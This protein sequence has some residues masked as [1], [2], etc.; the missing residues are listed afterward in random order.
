MKKLKE[1]FLPSSNFTPQKKERFFLHH[2][3]PITAPRITRSHASTSSTH[4]QS[5][6]TRVALINGKRT[7]NKRDFPSQLVRTHSSDDGKQERKKASEIGTI[8]VVPKMRE[9]GNTRKKEKKDSLKVKQEIF[10]HLHPTTKRK[11]ES[12]G[13]F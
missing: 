1:F 11:R 6:Y 2:F 10:A 9:K 12:A 8:V 7:R 5:Y 4:T 13:N 3:Q